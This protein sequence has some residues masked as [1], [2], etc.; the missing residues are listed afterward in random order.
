MQKTCKREIM[1]LAIGT[2][3]AH[4]SIFYCKSHPKL[5]TWGP[6]ELP[7][8]VAENSNVSYSVIVEIGR[9]RFKENRQVM[10]I[11]SILSE[12]HSID[13]SR[14]EIELLIDKFIFFI[15]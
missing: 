1:D 14:S 3:I 8:I 15:C 4:F 2:F 11:K 5:G 9:L 13:L 12:Q 6:K 10:E 7:A